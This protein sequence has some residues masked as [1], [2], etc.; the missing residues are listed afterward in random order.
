M[1]IFL[2]FIGDKKKL[3]N[4]T[5]ENKC[6]VL[7]HLRTVCNNNQSQCS[8]EIEIERRLI[9][10]WKQQEDAIFASTHKRV[11]SSKYRKEKRALAKNGN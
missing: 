1:K 5:I 9:G 6:K 4:Y 2:L 8:R 7:H 3:M 10:R 11:S